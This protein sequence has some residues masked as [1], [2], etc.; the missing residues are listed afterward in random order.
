MRDAGI[1][2]QSELHVSHPTVPRYELMGWRRA[3]GVT[4]GV[5]DRERSFRLKRRNDDVEPCLR[6]WTILQS[7][8]SPGFS[9]V[10]VS[11]QDHGTAIGMHET[12]LTG[13]RVERG[14]DGHVTSRPGLLLTVTLADCIPI[15]LLHPQ[16]GTGALLHAGWRG[17]AAGMLEAGVE[18]ICHVAG[19]LPRELVMHCGVGICGVCYAVGSEVFRAVTGEEPDGPPSLNLRENLARRGR[20]VGVGR[21]SVSAWCTV[22]DFERFHSYRRSGAGAG[23]MIAYLGRPAA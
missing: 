6:D 22:H 1:V 21:V 12:P 16:T 7:V 13:L 4:A 9:G 19:T 8:M 10:V 3:F 2:V 18:R 20:R 23:R 15:Y 17:T 14:L 5:T 11:A